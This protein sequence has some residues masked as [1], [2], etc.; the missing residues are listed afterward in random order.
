ME[1]ATGTG[2]AAWNRIA[3]RMLSDARGPIGRVLGVTEMLTNIGM[4]MRAFHTELRF[5]ELIEPSLLAVAH[6]NISANRVEHLP[7]Q[8]RDANVDYNEIIRRCAQ[9]V[10]EEHREK[11]A[12]QTDAAALLSCYHRGETLRY[13]EF[14]CKND[15]M[16]INLTIHLLRHPVSVDTHALFYFRDVHQRCI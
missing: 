11:F 12:Q 10:S 6:V 14:P 4:Q 5:M 9:E 2:E 3:E 8:V 7:R 1:G 15:G 16:W 13:L